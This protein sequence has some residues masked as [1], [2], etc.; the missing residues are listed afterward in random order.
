MIQDVK[1]ERLPE[2][3]TET[4]VG[5]EDPLVLE[6]DNPKKSEGKYEEDIVESALIEHET[7]SRSWRAATYNESIKKQPI[8]SERILKV[9]G[10]LTNCRVE[11]EVGGK[12]VALKGDSHQDIN[13]AISK[14]DVVDGWMVS[15]LGCSDTDNK[16]NGLVLTLNPPSHVQLSMFRRND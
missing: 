10:S 9:I 15:L 1:L 14:L 12:G 6:D 4:I 8:L 16:T 2:T 5:G 11:L 7:L 13:K 3:Q